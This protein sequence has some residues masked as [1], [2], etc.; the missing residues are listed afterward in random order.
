MPKPVSL[1]MFL[2]LVVGSGLAVGLLTAPGPW[3]AG[4][5]KPWF[6][7][8]DSVFGPVWTVLYILIAIAGWRVWKDGGNPAAMKAWWAQLILNLAWSPAFFVLN[9]LVL[10]LVV[11]IALLLTIIGFITL[12]ARTDPIAASLFLPYAAWVGFATLLNGSILM[13]NG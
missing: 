4:L 10:S 3:Y 2:L 9:N 13:L 7:P 5:A 6:N 1:L 8:P 12:A 11:I